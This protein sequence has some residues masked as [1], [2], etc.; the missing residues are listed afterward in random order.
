[1][2]I[3]FMGTPDFAARSLEMLIDRGHEIAGVFC[4][5]D[6]PA[7]RG[8]KLQAPPVKALA[9]ERGV[10]VYQPEKL[11]DGAAYEI[12][13]QLRPELNVVVAYGRILPDD[14]IFE[15]VYGTVN[16]HASLLPKYRGAAPI[17]W[18][19]LSGDAE[20]GVSTMYMAPE[21]DA[22]DVIYTRSTRIGEHESSGELFGRLAV[23][24]AELL[25]ETVEAIEQGTAP[26]CPQDHDKATFTTQI[27]KA[28]SPIDWSRPARLVMK[29][30]Y[31]L[32]PWPVATMDY[33]GVTLKVFS[34]RCTGH[35]SQLPPGSVVSVGKDGI[36]LAC[37]DGETV[38]IDSVQAP[39]KK[40]MA[41]ADY[42][43]G[44][45]PGAGR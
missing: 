4:Q 43:R 33:G 34:A 19:V 36:E 40:R 6:R 13:R 9:L 32:Q 10:P 27:T 45:R 20:T 16:L 14:I 44:H 37:G 3:L 26:R 41:A 5:P 11:R 29:Q 8:M 31:G 18:A 42:L 30:I 35:V 22:G 12:V 23:M 15:P 39:G 38:L 1:M 28:M 7:S 24:G 2:R 21:L 17:Q 25:A